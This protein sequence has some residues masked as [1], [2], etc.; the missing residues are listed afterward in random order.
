MTGHLL[1]DSPGLFTTLQDLG[2]FGQQNL[3]VPVSGALDA[4]ALRIANALVGNR[5]ALAG[6]EIR[7]AGPTMRVETDS[8]R[9]A[10]AGTTAA[11]EILGEAARVVP[12]W[13]SVRLARGDVFRIG[14]LRDTATCYC[15]VEGGFAVPALFDSQ[16]TYVRGRLG[17]FDGRALRAGDRLPLGQ[18][19]A[20]DRSEVRLNGSPPYGT[21][22]AV[23]V[24]LGPQQGHFTEAGIKTFLES[25]FIIS[26][27]ADRMG[28][29]LD[30]PVL[31]HAAGHDIVSDGIAT[32]SIQVPGTG[33]PIILLA[34]HQTTGGY[35]KIATVA[36]VDLPRLGRM[37]PGETLRFQAVTVEEAEAARRAQENEILRLIDGFAPVREDLRLDSETLLSANLISGV[38][39]SDE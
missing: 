25:S 13:H 21:G 36:S 6:L 29:R 15:A 5:E 35:P 16:S 22:D 20:P 10:L 7:G 8:V 19:E 37:R 39:S 2:R 11:L 18:P 1:V 31:E 9:I 38:V 23:R 28:L 34:D 12:G 3:G 33:L 32:G 4:I 26:N 24:V 30:G 14:P 17:G 27:Q